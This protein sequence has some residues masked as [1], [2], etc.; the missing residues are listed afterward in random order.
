MVNIREAGLNQQCMG[1]CVCLFELMHIC[2]L[3]NEDLK[4]ESQEK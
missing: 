4:R 2:L 1:V 3:V